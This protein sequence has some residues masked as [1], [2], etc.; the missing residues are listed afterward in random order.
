MGSLIS[1]SYFISGVI[2]HSKADDDFDG[3]NET[4]I[5]YSNSQVDSVSIDVN[6]NGFIDL[7]MDYKFGV[8]QEIK[9]ID[10]KDGDIIKQE[11]IY[12]NMTAEQQ[13][14]FEE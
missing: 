6:N 2:D 3:T 5:E 13:L 11:Y 8:L 10:E 1:F 12:L 4:Y 9:F 7:V 14:Y